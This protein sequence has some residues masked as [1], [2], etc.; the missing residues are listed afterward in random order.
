M[1]V[2]EQSQA[3]EFYLAG[4]NLLS[5]HARR[6]RS[7]LVGCQAEDLAVAPSVR[8]DGRNLFFTFEPVR[9]ILVERV[10]GQCHISFER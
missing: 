9:A 5:L 3:S 10:Y 1:V 8:R 7:G 2:T 6:P 4:L